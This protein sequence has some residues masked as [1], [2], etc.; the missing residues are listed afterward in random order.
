MDS[1]TC[2]HITWGWA[3]SW[4]CWPFDIKQAA[5]PLGQLGVVG[6]G[7]DSNL[8]LIGPVLGVNPPRAVGLNLVGGQG[9]GLAVRPQHQPLAGQGQLALVVEGEAARAG[10]LHAVVGLDGK[11][12][13][14]LDG[15]VQGQPGLLQRALL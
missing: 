14:P 10:V 7:I 1:S 15:K 11:E 3:W 12:A 5:L 13:V 2:F 6:E 4:A 8:T 9:D